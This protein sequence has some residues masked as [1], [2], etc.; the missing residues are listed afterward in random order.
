MT[1]A[2]VWPCVLLYHQIMLSLDAAGMYTYARNS[3]HGGMYGTVFMYAPCV[4]LGSVVFDATVQ[5]AL[6]TSTASDH[7][8]TTDGHKSSDVGAAAAAT[9]GLVYIDGAACDATGSEPAPVQRSSYHRIGATASSST[10]A[11]P[12]PGD[13]GASDSGYDSGIAL[14]P[15]SATREPHPCH[16]SPSG[17]VYRDRAAPSSESA[18]TDSDGHCVSW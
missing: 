4:V 6:S 13:R 18:S 15:L 11:V 7:H 17:G 10:P 5:P 2:P 12:V 3:V 1:V 16:A 8:R 14:L 9:Q